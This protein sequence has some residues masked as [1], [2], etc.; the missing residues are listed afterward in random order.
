MALRKLIC[1]KLEL[2]NH[3]NCDHGEDMKCVH[4]YVIEALNSNLDRCD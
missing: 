2:G 3:W 4:D 1:S